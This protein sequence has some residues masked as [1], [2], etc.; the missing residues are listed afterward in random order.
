[1]VF[2]FT[3]AIKNPKVEIKIR[4]DIRIFIELGC[5]FFEG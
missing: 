2:N 5:L 4:K 3:A 1:M